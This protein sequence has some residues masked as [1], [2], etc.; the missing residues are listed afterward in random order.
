MPSL[1]LIDAH[2]EMPIFCSRSR[3]LINSL[4]GYAKREQ[5][6][7]EAVG[8]RGYQVHALRGVNLQI[9][10][11]ERVGLLGHNGA[12]KTTLLRVLSGAYEPTRGSISIVGTVSS[13]TDLTLG[14]DMEASGLENIRLRA[15]YLGMNSSKAEWLERD[16]IEFTELNSYLHLPV[17]TY[18]SGMMLRL[19]F[20]ISTAVSPDILLMD[21]MIGAGDAQFLQKAKARLDRLMRQASILVLASHNEGIIRSFCSRAI[22]LSGGGVIFDGAVDECLE[23]YRSTE[24]DRQR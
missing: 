13:L 22:C 20:A 9:R 15:L 17:R 2:V 23:Y 10:D 3:G 6:R 8:L 18:S 1:K 12:G 5:N 19:A 24:A 16:V 11:G 4:F 7:I 14:M 21:E